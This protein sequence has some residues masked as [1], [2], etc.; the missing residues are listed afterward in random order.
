MVIFKRLSLKAL[1]A[2]QDSP[3]VVL[4]GWLGSKH[5]LTNCFSRSWRKR[6][7]RVTKR[8]HKCF[9]QTVHKYTS[10][11]Q[12]KVTSVAHTLSLSLFLSHPLKPHTHTHTPH[13]HTQTEPIRQIRAN[14]ILGDLLV[15]WCFE[16]SQPQRITSGL[17]L[18]GWRD[19]FSE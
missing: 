4:C 18:K 8:L 16:P 11:H 6:G 15:G 19:R 12:R 3:D 1:S 14:Q 7:D 13:T 17:I 9:S 10:V 5:Q 2:L